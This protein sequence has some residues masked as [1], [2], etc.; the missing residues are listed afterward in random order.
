MTRRVPASRAGFTLIE[1]IG[2]LVIFALGVIM[3]L[4]LTTTLSRQ[5]ERSA[6]ASLVTAEGGERL[7]SLGALTYAALTLGTKT[8][9]LTF[10]GKGYQMTQTVTQFSP[11]VRKASVSLVP[12]SPPGPSFTASTFLADQW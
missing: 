1:V 2:A 10:R 8:N 3:L 11:L 12:T 6:V 4:N 5:L 9:A 7:D